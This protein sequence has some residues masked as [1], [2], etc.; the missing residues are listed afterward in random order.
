MPAIVRCP[1]GCKLQVPVRKL[2]DNFQC[3]KCSSS[4]FVSQNQ[5][6][7]FQDDRKHILKANLSSD[8][9]EISS[10]DIIFLDGESTNLLVDVSDE[11]SKKNQADQNPEPPPV[12]DHTP[13]DIVFTN[14]S[15]S[16]AQPITPDLKPGQLPTVPDPTPDQQ[17]QKAVAKKQLEPRPPVQPEPG[18]HSQPIPPLPPGTPQIKELPPAV[19]QP[20]DSNS[21][22]GAKQSAIN[23]SAPD[24]ADSK[25]D[26]NNRSQKT[27]QPATWIDRFFNDPENPGVLHRLEKRWKAYSLGWAMVVIGIFLLGPVIYTMLQWI[28]KDYH[29]PMGRWSYLLIFF[30][31]FQF[32]YALFLFQLPDWS[33]TR[34]VSYLMLL[35]TVMSSFMLAVAYL[36]QEANNFFNFLQLSV[37]NKNLVCS[38][39]T[40]MAIGFGLMSYLCGRT[41]QQWIGEE[42]RLG[43]LR[44]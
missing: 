26:L 10:E 21:G 39:L 28:G 19:P 23:K 5:I 2:F 12:V 43:G 37:V 40:V 41:T 35:M 27:N 32:L 3:P 18:I 15:K 34:F 13:S 44:A 4:L 30:S 20:T 24:Q 25:T 11:L 33:S 7:R 36:S 17:N 31:G 29:L 38:W 16:L 14:E 42:K 22:V 8:L 6:D 1:N 9:V